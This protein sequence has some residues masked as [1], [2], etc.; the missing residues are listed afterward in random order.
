MADGEKQKALFVTT[1]DQSLAQVLDEIP[2]LDVSKLLPNFPGYRWPPV[3]CLIYAQEIGSGYLKYIPIVAVFRERTRL[4]SLE[5]VALLQSTRWMLKGLP[6]RFLG[7]QDRYQIVPAGSMGQN[8][9]HPSAEKDRQCH[10]CNAPV[11]QGLRSLSGKE[12]LEVKA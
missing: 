7:E 8:E 10:E 1:M 11:P 6:P 12:V 4:E 3:A 9:V 2:Q 5:A